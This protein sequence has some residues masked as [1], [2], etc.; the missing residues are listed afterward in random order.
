MQ[1]DD[2]ILQ[3]FLVEAQEIIKNLDS[4]LI[5]LESSPNDSALLNAVFRAFRTIKGGA[6]FLNLHALVEVAL[7]AED[8][9]DLLRKGTR[10]VTPRIMDA[11]FHVHDTLRTMFAALRAGAIPEHATPELLAELVSLASGNFRTGDA[12]TPGSG[13]F[14]E[15]VA[16]MLNVETTPAV[17]ASNVISDDEFDQMLDRLTTQESAA[18]AAASAHSGT[19]TDDE[20]DAL[21]DNLQGP[22]KSKAAAPAAA[23]AV[24]AEKLEAPDAATENKDNTIR[25]GT[26]VLDRVMNMVGGLVRIRNRL[27]NLQAA[28]SNPEITQAVANLEVVTRDLE[29]TAMKIRMQPIKKVFDRFPRVVRDLARS[30]DKEIE[31]IL[32]GEETDLDTH[33]VEALSD[34]LMHLVRNAC[35]HGV[36]TPAE[37]D[38]AGKSRAGRVKLSAEKIDDQVVL[39]IA[40]DG[41]GMNAEVLRTKV[42]EKG[43]LDA[44]SA[45]RLSERE[46]FELI[47][48]PGFSTK[49]QIS[50]VSGGGV[51]MDVVKTRIAQINGS[52]EID[53]KLV[54]GTIIQIRVPLTLASIRTLL[55]MVGNQVFALPLVNVKEII[56]FKLAYAHDVNGEKTVMVREKVLPLIYLSRWLVNEVPEYVSDRGHVVIVRVSNQTI[57]LLVDQL[58]GQEEIVFKPSGTLLH[59][60][61][62]VS[63]ATITGNGR[64]ARI[65]DLPSLI[66]AYGRG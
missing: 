62:G 5:E 13:E 1:L 39:T 6:G 48:L 16:A 15:V 30:L 46:C 7:R 56:D 4:Q 50:D 55:V 40:D 60:T 35:D 2:E 57:G 34:P 20:F 47:F 28:I 8:I 52:I 33:L 32:E 36:E 23:P 64:I 45:A 26:E 66:D 21:L 18:P 41:N 22:P 17:G 53:S 59:G 51:G 3:N 19:I 27:K 61:G 14:D 31:L 11:F 9:C 37:R 25:V 49:D 44:E 10:T 24:A 54:A 58:I 12:V 42:V 63:G 38:R 65:L 29:S 43:L